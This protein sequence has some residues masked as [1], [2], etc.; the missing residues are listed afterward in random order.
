MARGGDRPG[1]EFGRGQS[2]VPRTKESPIGRPEVERAHKVN[3]TSLI[4]ENEVQRLVTENRKLDMEHKASLGLLL[5][6]H[7]IGK[8]V[9]LGRA[10]LFL[11][12]RLKIK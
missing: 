4:F 1:R 10:C 12:K 5:S 9:W 2:L 3:P 7:L 6:R 11:Q 8:P